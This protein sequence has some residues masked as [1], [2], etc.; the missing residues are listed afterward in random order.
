[1]SRQPL[2]KFAN[3]LSE[4]TLG[5]PNYLN[6]IRKKVPEFSERSVICL[7]ADQA[8]AVKGIK[9]KTVV[10][11]PGQLPPDQ[12]IF[13]HLYNLPDDDQFWKN[14]LQFTRQVFTN[15]AREVMNH[16]AI[17]GQTVDVKERVDAYHG[18]LKP[19]DIFKRFYQDENFQ[20]LVSSG[21]K[22]YNPWKHWVATHPVV[23]K[24]F[25]ESFKAAIYGVMKNGY[26]VDVTKLNAL[27]V[28]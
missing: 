10:I 2:K 16:F 23:S 22:S 21:A 4:I 26:G 6:L 20:R 25:L 14:E 15:F 13:E 9:S 19:R 28:K 11:L 17:N 8:Q 7:D 24:D 12:L 5:A 3:P 27:V 1:M 18:P